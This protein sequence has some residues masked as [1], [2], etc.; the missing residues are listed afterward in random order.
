MPNMLKWMRL[1]FISLGL[2]AV[3][4][5]IAI[6]AHFVSAP[7]SPA[8]WESALTSSTSAPV[9]AV[10][11]WQVQSYTDEITGARHFFATQTSREGEMRMDVHCVVGTVGYTALSFYSDQLWPGVEGHYIVSYRINRQ[12][13][14]SMERWSGIEHQVWPPNTPEDNFQP[15]LVNGGTLVIRVDSSVMNGMDDQHFDLNGLGT[16]MRELKRD[17]TAPR[18]TGAPK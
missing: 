3:F 14:V 17:C 8:A 16:T 4:A 10:P 7:P 9:P 12:P 2:L 11:K 13:G 5:A 15:G 18:Q 6:V 1:T